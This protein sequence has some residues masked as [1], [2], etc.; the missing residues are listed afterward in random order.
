MT[1]RGGCAAEHVQDLGR[2]LLRLR[3][4]ADGGALA[5][6]RERHV[7]ES[8]PAVLLRSIV[9]EHIQTAELADRAIDDGPAERLASA[10]WAVER[11]RR[12]HAVVEPGRPVEQV[13]QRR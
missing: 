7:L 6:P 11:S 3:G 4:A 10:A 2:H 5:K 9:D 12:Q 13:E 8:L 1:S